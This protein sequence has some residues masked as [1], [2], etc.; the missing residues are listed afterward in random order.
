M[1]E[2]IP[3]SYI[4][5]LSRE[6]LPM[7]IS[8]SYYLFLGYFL[9]C[10]NKKILF[11]IL[12][13]NVK[14]SIIYWKYLVKIKLS[15]CYIYF[16]IKFNNNENLNLEDNNIIAACLNYKCLR[17]IF[18]KK[19]IDDEDIRNRIVSVRKIIEC[20]NSIF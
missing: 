8:C 14:K 3:L 11:I 20:L 17:S 6:L 19:Q 18:Y 4:T 10:E 1:N 5:K 7:Q 16:Y 13:Y 9:F 15:F 12:L 2:Y